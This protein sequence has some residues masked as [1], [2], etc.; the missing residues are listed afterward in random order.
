M[1]EQIAILYKNALRFDEGE[2]IKGEEYKDI[3]QRQEHLQD[4]LIATFGKG[5]IALLDDYTGT[6]YEEMELEAQ[7]F[8]QEG[9][10]AAMGADRAQ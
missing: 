5:V 9:Y 6:L 2:I 4:L 7:H 10:W 1:Q 8:F 3:M